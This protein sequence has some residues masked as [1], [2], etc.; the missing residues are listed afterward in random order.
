MEKKNGTIRCKLSVCNN[1]TKGPNVTFLKSR[2]K[3][4]QALT[5]FQCG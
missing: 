2:R 3:K 1:A 4:S 5:Q